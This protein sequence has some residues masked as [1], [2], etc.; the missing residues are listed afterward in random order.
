MRNPQNRINSIFIINIHL[1]YFSTLYIHKN[2]YTVF[3]FTL[4][5]DFN[6]PNVVLLKP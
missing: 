2:K 3:F 4:L 5:V 1:L 6:S